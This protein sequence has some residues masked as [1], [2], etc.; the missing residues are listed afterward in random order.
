MG[1]FDRMKKKFEDAGSQKKVTHVVDEKKKNQA[2]KKESKSSGLT[3]EEIARAQALETGTVAPVEKQDEK[4]KKDAT[5]K[6]TKF[7]FKILVRPLITEKSSY[8]SSE[9]KYAFE[10][11]P[12]ATKS[13][14]K[15]AVH[16]AYNVAPVAVHIVRV[17]G[18]DIRFGYQQGR[19]KNWKKAIITLP[20]GKTIDVY[21]T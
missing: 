20:K 9:S 18:K 2:K 10:V 21:Q 5:P 1:L 3:K 15:K 7:A 11:H 6:D 13:E 17:K 14:I 12:E 8:L 19:T 4:K 16:A